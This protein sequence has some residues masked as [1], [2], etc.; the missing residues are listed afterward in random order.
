VNKFS[1]TIYLL[2]AIHSLQTD[3]TSCQHSCRASKTEHPY[4]YLSKICTCLLENCNYLGRPDA[5]VYCRL[6][7]VLWWFYCL[8]FFFRLFM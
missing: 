7:R 5:A 8:A 1:F 6:I 4:L 3:D 2:A